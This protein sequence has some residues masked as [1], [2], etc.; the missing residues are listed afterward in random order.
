[1][2]NAIGNRLYTAKVQADIGAQFDQEVDGFL[3]ISVRKQTFINAVVASVPAENFEVAKKQEVKI[4]YSALISL[5]AYLA[6]VMKGN[7]TPNNEVEAAV[8]LINRV[9]RV[10][11]ELISEHERAMVYSAMHTLEAFQTK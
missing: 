4:F 3:N 2:F 1:M 11:L 8:C 10:N 9:E 7:I 6:E 5:A